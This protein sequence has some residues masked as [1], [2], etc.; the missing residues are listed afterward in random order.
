LA[1]IFKK[2]IWRKKN[3]KLL[4]GTDFK[5]YL[6][7]IISKTHLAGTFWQEHFGGI[8]FFFTIR[9]LYVQNAPF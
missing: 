8:F 1:G 4:G 9:E 6:A 5:N 7:G 2:N 3:Q